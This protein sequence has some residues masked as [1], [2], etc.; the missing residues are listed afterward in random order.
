MDC[1][2]VSLVLLAGSSNSGVPPASLSLTLLIGSLESSVIQ[3]S[4]FS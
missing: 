1:K 2:L 3:E 4:L